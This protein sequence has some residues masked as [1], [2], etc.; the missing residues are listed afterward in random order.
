MESRGG[1]WTFSPLLFAH[2]AACLCSNQQDI[3]IC[4][5]AAER[6]ITALEQ[7]KY[8]EEAEYLSML[9]IERL[10]SCTQDHYTIGQLFRARL[11]LARIQCRR[12]K[13]REARQ[14]FLLA[15]RQ[16]ETLSRLDHNEDQ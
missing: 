12:G 7:S 5:S 1:V 9:R 8:L 13:R 15:V 3:V 4:L 11:Y 16:H 6:L 10:Q 14:T 2:V